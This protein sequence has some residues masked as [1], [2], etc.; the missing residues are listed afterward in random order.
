MVEFGEERSERLER[1]PAQ[2]KVL[3]AVRKKSTCPD[4]PSAG[5]IT[6]PAPLAK[7][8]HADGF[9]AQTLNDKIADNI[10]HRQ[11]KRLVRENIDVPIAN[12]IDW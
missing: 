3:V 9:I 10:P 12:L 1:I 6:Q 4:C 5:V 2:H 11:A 8:K 7:P